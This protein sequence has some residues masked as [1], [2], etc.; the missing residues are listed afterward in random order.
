MTIEGCRRHKVGVWEVALIRISHQGF[1]RVGLD[2]RRYQASLI[3]PRRPIRA[4]RL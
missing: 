2:P 1:G 3:I 4:D